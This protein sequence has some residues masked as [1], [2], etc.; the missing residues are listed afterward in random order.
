M[1]AVVYEDIRT[2]G[3]R[4]VPDARLEA[5]SDAVVRVTSSAICG[6][7]LHMYDGRTGAEP[8]LVLGHE[9]LGVVEQVGPCVETITPGMRVAIPTHLYCGTCH[10]CARGLTAACLRA[11]PDGIGAAYGYAGMGPYRGAQAELL[12]VPWA[13]A[14]CIRL[15]GQPGDAHEDDFVLLADAFVTGWH[16]TRLAD[17]AAGD[18]VAVFGAGT[19]GLLAAYSAL[20]QGAR[21]VYSVDGVDARLDMASELGATPV[22]FRA[23]DPVDRI[24]ELRTR[25]GLPIGEEKLDGVDKVIDAVGFQAHDRTH[26]DRERPNQVVADAARLVNACGAVAVIGVYPEKDLNPQPG[27]TADGRLTVP[28]GTFFNKGVSV[29]FGRTHDRRYTTH[30]RDLITSGR[31]HPGAIVTH[32]G[33]LDYAA[34]LYRQF[35]KREDGVIKAVLHP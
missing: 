17:V 20:L 7:D 8:G 6:T 30:L 27:E 11:R 4:D 33:R 29:R 13:D 21:A 15:P 25:A 18:T 10:L 26:P 14:N 23:G 34:E 5:D 28:W 2:V 32:H 3:V 16:A 31:A 9:P 12:R 1:K 19:I 35:D 24:R 22:D